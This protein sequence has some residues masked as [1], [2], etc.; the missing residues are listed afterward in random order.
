MKRL[1]FAP[2]S[3]ALSCLS[4]AIAASSPAQAQSPLA[5]TKISV[6][7]MNDPFAG[8]LVKLAPAFKQKTGIDV[9]IDILSYPELLTRLTADFVGKTRNY[10]VVT[11]DIVWA[12]Q[13]AENGYTVDLGEWIKRDAAQLDLPDIYPAVLTGLGNYKGKQIA[14]PL[15]AYSNVLVY[16][17]DVFDAAGVKPPETMTELIAA[18]QKVTDP[19]KNIYGWMA[20][21]RKGAASAQDWMQYNAQIGGSI[22]ASDGK[23]ALNSAANVKSL[24]VY[25]DLFKKAAPP[26]A[27]NYDWAARHEAYRQGLVASHQTWSISLPSYEDPETSKVVGKTAVTLAPTEAGMAKLYGLG[28]WGLAINAAVDAKKQAAGWE[29]IKW[30]GSAETQKTLLRSGVGVFTRKSAVT[31]P[32]L[33]VRYPF[34]KVVDTSL[35][36]AD[37]DFR[38][39][40]PQYPQ[41]QDAL[42]TAVNSVLVAGTDPKA[43]LDEAQARV[44][45]AW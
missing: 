45:K 34:L 42:G 25:R 22:L 9:K 20:N 2:F 4:L 26:G 21:G 27:N 6:A 44:L 3:I 11:M 37:A 43:A 23:P 1:A 10:D 5:G 35:I 28:G 41:I 31:D 40:I 24:A 12:G 39:R 30:A 13:F 32:Q 19:A 15:A 36:H 8:A 33:Q 29:F 38:P 17:K 16:R 7:S 14:F 18:A